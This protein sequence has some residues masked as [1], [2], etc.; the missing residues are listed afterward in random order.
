MLKFQEVHIYLMKLEHFKF[1]LLFKWIT[2]LKKRLL[3]SSIQFKKRVLVEEIILEHGAD[4]VQEFTQLK[5]QRKLQMM[6]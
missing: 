4:G 3:I 6:Q 1:M 5:N 2:V